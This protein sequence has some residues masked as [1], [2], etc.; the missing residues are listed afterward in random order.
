M[1]EKNN[2]REKQVLIYSAAST[3]YQ[4]SGQGDAAAEYANKAIEMAKEVNRD[5]YL[6]DAYSTLS[7]VYSSKGDIQKSLEYAKKGLEISERIGSLNLG[8]SYARTA[9]A[10]RNT[11]ALKAI[12]YFNKA[13]DFFKNSHDKR[14]EG[15]VYGSLGSIYEQLSQNDKALEYYK[16]SLEIAEKYNDKWTALSTLIVLPGLYDR[17]GDHENAQATE[18]KCLELLVKLPE[19]EDVAIQ[20]QLLG[21]SNVKRNPNKAEEYFLKSLKILEKQ[22]SLRGE[23]LTEG[24]YYYLA[25]FYCKQ[26]KFGEGLIYYNKLF[27][28]AKKTNDQKRMAGIYGVIGLVKANLKDIGGALD[29]YRKAYE[30]DSTLKDSKAMELL[31]PE[32]QK[33]EK[34]QLEVKDY[35]EKKIAEDLL[36]RSGIYVLNGNMELALVNAQKALGIFK[37]NNDKQKIAASLRV[38]AGIYLTKGD[39]I[40]AQSFLNEALPI[41]NETKD[42]ESIAMVHGAMALFFEHIGKY[43]DSEKELNKAV[44]SLGDSNMEK[45]YWA[46]YYHCLATLNYKKGKFKEAVEFF[47]KSIDANKELADPRV[48]SFTYLMAGYVSYK[49]NNLNEAISF[50]KSASEL[51]DSI[52]EQKTLTLSSLLIGEVQNAGDFLGRK[53]YYEKAIEHARLED[54][55]RLQYIVYSEAA[56]FMKNAGTSPEE[57]HKYSNMAKAIEVIEGNDI[58]SDRLD[59]KLKEFIDD[60]NFFYLYWL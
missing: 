51:A 43:E 18:K 36:Q 5:D 32:I 38:I 10:Y 24:G 11:D 35:N 15:N 34:Y 56:R 12:E 50:L 7:G 60:L 37:N 41:V 39:Q 42:K 20:Y 29:S 45:P 31:A 2:D 16:K 58:K 14:R 22:K 1:A 53:N 23:K 6:V 19:D 8:E 48:L 26:N 59:V 33:L 52:N 28:C 3:T 13:I 54:D 21:L 4:S 44:A 9:I 30:L 17:L 25:D 27:E 46:T 47:K 40:K 49:A 55:K 57:Y